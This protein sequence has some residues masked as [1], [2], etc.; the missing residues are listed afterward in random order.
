MVVNDRWDVERLELL[1]GPQK[2]SEVMSLVGELRNEKDILIWLLDNQGTFMTKST[3]EVLRIKM[4]IF[5]WA[6]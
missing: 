2:A 1:V 5:D 4:H 3:W 6:R